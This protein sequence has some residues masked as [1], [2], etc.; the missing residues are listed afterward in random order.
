MMWHC[1][2]YCF[3]TNSGFL[4]GLTLFEC[5]YVLRTVQWLFSVPLWL[6]LKIRWAHPE[7]CLGGS[8]LRGLNEERWTRLKIKGTIPRAEVQTDWIKH[9]NKRAHHTNIRHSLLPDWDPV[10]CGQVSYTPTRLHQAFAS[11]SVT[12][13]PTVSPN[14]CFSTLR[15]FV[16]YFVTVRRK[17]KT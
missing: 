9:R 12:S 17:K 13:S 15:C 16:A 10:W 6:A 2:H 8:F 3:R 7:A 14:T 5:L 11:G 4:E 1:G